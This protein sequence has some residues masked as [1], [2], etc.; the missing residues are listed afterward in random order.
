LPEKNF[1][2]KAV[3][4][5]MD[6]LMLDSERPAIE[7]LIRAA[8]KVGWELSWELGYKLIGINEESSRKI[9]TETLG[10]DFPYEQIKENYG[11][12]LVEDVEK[13]G[14]PQRPGLLV[15][16]DHL[17]AL[18]LPMAVATS[19]AR[20]IALWK[21]EKAGIAG[22]FSL[23]VCGDEVE[24]GKPAPDIFLKAAELLHVPPAECVGFEDSP[25]G[26]R[27]LAAAE[28]RSVFVKDLV[29]P[30][31]EVLATVWRRFDRLDEAVGLF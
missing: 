25:A 27:S 21:L 2:P 4:F 31:P 8:A 30:P 23:M 7:T 18:R 29:E 26:L 5:D 15:L 12:L 10:P 20:K 1:T 13:N 16:L 17:K 9:L 6:G 24:N 3:I 19:T 28:I 22:R 14:I 11:R